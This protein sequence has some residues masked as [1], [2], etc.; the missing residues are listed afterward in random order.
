VCQ[1]STRETT[2]KREREA[3]TEPEID[4]QE[5]RGAGAKAAPTGGFFSSSGKT[6]SLL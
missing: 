2:S 6:S 5:L 3:E 4:F 1:S